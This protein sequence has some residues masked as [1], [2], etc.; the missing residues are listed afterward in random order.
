M[1]V[2]KIRW[3][4]DE[5][6]IID[7]TFIAREEDLK[8]EVIQDGAHLKLIVNDVD[9]DDAGKYAVKVEEAFSEIAIDVREPPI[10]IVESLM[11]PPHIDVV[12][13][14]DLVV[15]CRLNRVVDGIAFV[16]D[17]Q[18]LQDDGSSKYETFISSATGDCVLTVRRLSVTDTGYYGV[19]APEFGVLEDLPISV[20]EFVFATPLQDQ[21]TYEGEPALL[22]CRVSREEAEVTCTLNGE[23]V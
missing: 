8:Y 21:Q 15:K 22:G 14:S 4:K 10:R 6:A 13:K 20:R 18:V 3:L 1:P 9:E 5:V 17:G 23:A 7:G 12:E 16:K 2:S 11:V 19:S